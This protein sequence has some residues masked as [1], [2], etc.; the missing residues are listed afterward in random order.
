MCSTLSSPDLF[1]RRKGWR[2]KLI[3]TYALL[4]FF[5]EMEIID[6]TIVYE[7]RT[8]IPRQQPENTSL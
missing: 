8:K 7:L 6:P 4:F 1:I 3:S 5:G 2:L